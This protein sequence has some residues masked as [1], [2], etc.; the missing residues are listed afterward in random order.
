MWGS[1]GEVVRAI[2]ATT[3]LPESTPTLPPAEPAARDV[4]FRL[5]LSRGAP[6]AWHEYAR[7]AAWRIVQRTI[8]RVGRPRF[9]VALLRAFGADIHPTAHFMGTVRVHHPWLLRVGRYSSVGDRVQIY[10]LGPIVIGEHTSISQNVHLCA[11]THDYKNPTMPLIRSPITIGSGVWICA[12]AF[13]GPG[14]RVG[15]NSVVAARAVVV[16]DVVP[17]VI[18]RGN[19]AKTLKDRPMP[20]RSDGSEA[21]AG[22]GPGGGTG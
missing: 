12:D 7:K 18:V 1:A 8:F 3:V 16:G 10:N 11:G 20:G 2:M 9:R 21:G 15:D 4:F 6:Y 17:G 14:V 19:P 13:I 22:K 5:D